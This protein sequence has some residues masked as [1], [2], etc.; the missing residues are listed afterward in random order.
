MITWHLGGAVS[1]PGELLEYAKRLIMKGHR[2][3]VYDAAF[4]SLWGGGR[5]P[6]SRNTELKD[7][8][9]AID[10]FN[11]HGIGLDANFSGVIENHEL[12]DYACNVV[13]E[14]L[15]TYP[16]N[17]VILSE[18]K[19]FDHIKQRY[20]SLMITSSITAVTPKI[21]G[22]DYY[23]LNADFNTH[24]EDVVGLGID[25]LQILV[26]ENCYQNCN[27]RG[28][29]YKQLSLMMKRFDKSFEDTCICENQSGGRFKMRL[30][31]DQ[32]LDMHEMG[33]SHFKVQGRQDPIE[34]E[35]GPYI[36][37]VILKSKGG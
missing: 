10:L 8:I 24:L 33:I 13:L 11:A 12:N 6:F 26:N 16:K 37:D 19:L 9:F 20:P 29:H 23:A 7:F 35:I 22:C 15:E 30:D 25:K 18:Q 34:S 1:Y 27:E 28:Q 2:V 4:T 14:K 5:I 32:I 36:L 17:G 21:K 31:M 3:Q